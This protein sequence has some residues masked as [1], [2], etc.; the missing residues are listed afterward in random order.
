MINGKG[1]WVLTLTVVAGAALCGSAN[2]G[3]NRT[4]AGVRVV[5]TD[6]SQFDE[7]DV[8][9]GADVSF[10]LTDW[11]AADV[12]VTFFPGDLGDVVPFSGSRTEGLAGIRFGPRFGRTGIFAVVRPGLV[13][14]AE[15]PD[16]IAC[17][18]IF[19]PPLVCS[20]AQGKTVFALNY[21]GGFD[22]VVGERMVVRME[23]GDL[24]LKYPGPGIGRDGVFET[25]LWS[26][27]LRATASVGLGF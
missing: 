26:H 21:G 11:L 20:L 6:Y 2:A 3:Q 16:P 15:A 18:A 5:L 7:R 12:Q 13:R 25:H 27:N 10:R 1:P 19:P 24:M 9:V 4:D 22:T 14:F 23:I 17:I 8:G